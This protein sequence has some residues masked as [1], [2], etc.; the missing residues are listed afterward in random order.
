MNIE[1]KK[2]VPYIKTMFK[3]GKNIE[4]ISNCLGIKSDEFY[5]KVKKYSSEFSDLNFK[6]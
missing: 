5:K 3:E 4:E 6:K 1:F 2:I